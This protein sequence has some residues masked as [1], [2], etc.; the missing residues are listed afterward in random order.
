MDK[1]E[2][3]LTA[4][5]NVLGGIENGT[6]TTSSALLQC[7]KIARLLND[8]D[9]IAWLQYEYGGYPRDQNGKILS[10]IWK[11]ADKN[12]R[13]YTKEGERY[14]FSELASELE[15]SIKAQQS[16]INNFST[17]GTS[18]SGEY[19]SA[20]MSVLTNHVARNT[21]SLLNDIIKSEKQLSILKSKYYEYA[22]RKHIEISF[23]NV[24]ADIFYSYRETVDS[25]FA[26]LSPEVIDKLKAIED[27]INSD[28]PELYSQALT[29]CRRLF[30]GI[31]NELF[32]KYFPDYS[33][34]KYETKSGKKIQVSGDRYK[35][36]LFAIV[37]TLQEKSMSN[38]VVGSNIIHTLDWI[39]NLHDLQ[40][41]GVHS[42]ITKQDAMQ[43]IIH[44]YICL[45]DI[46]RLQ[47]D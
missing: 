29:T 5:A 36:R 43:C 4:C 35:N 1:I 7:L 30:E 22:L 47:N 37:E 41:K 24:V 44:T 31:A 28:N 32:N 13:G 39:D 42:D 23:G 19:A 9:S 6:L 14:I 8:L 17:Q 40:C 33:H 26:R 46:L 21:K 3:A 2:Q 20:S 27:K 25:Y 45:G 12:G 18:V 11:V 16:A 38:S 15:A 34:E 10:A